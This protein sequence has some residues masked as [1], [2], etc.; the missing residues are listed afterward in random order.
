MLIYEYS[1]NKIKY[2]T[3]QNMSSIY[4]FQTNK[5]VIEVKSQTTTNFN[6]SELIENP[7]E[8]KLLSYYSLS[9]SIS[10][11]NH[12]N[13]YDKYK[14]DKNTQILTVEPSFNDWI[15]FSF[16]YDGQTNG[17]QTGFF[18]ENCKVAIRTCLFKCGS[19]SNYFS[20]CDLGICKTNF[21]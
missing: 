12:S 1:S 11:T 14:F 20:Q 19:C 17:M 16:Y 4:T 5:K 2:C 9:Y 8:H 13:S 15:T 7:T 6:V 21:T 18:L 10:T 3:I